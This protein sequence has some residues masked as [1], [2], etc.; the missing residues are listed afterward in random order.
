[1]G[2]ERKL[3][4][5]ER[6]VQAWTGLSDLEMMNYVPGSFEQ[7]VNEDGDMI[8]NATLRFSFGKAETVAHKQKE[9]KND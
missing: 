2:E 8:F 9:E 5:E 7:S 4:P 1:M 3:T 6:M